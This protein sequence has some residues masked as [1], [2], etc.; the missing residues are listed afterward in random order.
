MNRIM[1]S[2][3]IFC[4]FFFLTLTIS[5]F[6]VNIYVGRVVKVSDGDTFTLL[7]ADSTQER[8]RMH[9][10]D[11][12][13]KKG[14]QP[15][16]RAAKDYLSSLIA[17]KTVTVRSQSRDRYGRILGVVSTSEVSDVNLEMIRTGMAWH[18]SYYDNTEAYKAAEV[19]ARKNKLGLW[20]DE[21]PVNPYE[22]RKR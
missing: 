22:W 10:I 11:A 17:G 12:P 6:A 4:L 2:K 20:K 9:G 16:S 19:Y 14:G 5:C 3:S 15:Y 13:E 1:R 18:Y 21:N 7:L 8:V